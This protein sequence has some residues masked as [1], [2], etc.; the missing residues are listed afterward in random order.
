M[1]KT[2]EEA[3]EKERKLTKIRGD[4]CIAYQFPAGHWS[5]AWDGSEVWD[6][7]STT[8]D[9]YEGVRAQQTHEFTI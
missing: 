1:A 2:M 3:I 8:G 9:I 6:R 4:R 5:V 7:L